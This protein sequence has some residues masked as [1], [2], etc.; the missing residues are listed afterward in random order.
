MM[1]TVSGIALDIRL[2]LRW[3][4]RRRVLAA[5]AVASLALGIGANAAVF[6]LVDALLF[7]PFPVAKSEEFV[8]VG[9]GRES[10]PTGVSGPDFE[11]LRQMQEV[12][13]NLA[14][15]VDFTFS[16]RVRESTERLEGGLVTSSFLEVLGVSPRPGRSFLRSEE[17]ERAPV[18]V[19]SLEKAE[20]AMKAYARALEQSYPDTNAGVSAH[21]TP[22]SENR[23]S[24]PDVRDST[25]SYLGIVFGVVGVVFLI[26]VTNVAGLRLA[27]LW[28]RAPE[29]SLRRALGASRARVLRQF[30]VENVL[31]YASA[32]GASVVVAGFLIRLLERLTLFA[33]RSPILI[34]GSMAARWAPPWS[35]RF[36]ERF[37]EA[38]RPPW[39]AATLPPARPASSGR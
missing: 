35:W 26:A 19:V 4:V 38:S 9:S 29:L 37:S 10:N 1:L 23:L 22:F 24:N 36:R 39:Q 6:S 15:Q 2:A 34:C 16:V 13:T 27:D 20:T 14:A 30:L 21:L 11:D 5:T 3:L 33:S 31:L 25:R 17:D 28:D 18:A 12:F 7:R 8:R 32:F